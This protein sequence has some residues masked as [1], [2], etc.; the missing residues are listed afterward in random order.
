M[1]VLPVELMK[2]IEVFAPLF[3]ERVWC[4]VPMLLGG[5]ILAPGKRT[6]RRCCG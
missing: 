6:V 1:G 4:H 2:I 5:A 3:S